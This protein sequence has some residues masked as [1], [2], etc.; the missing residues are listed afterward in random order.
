MVRVAVHPDEGRLLCQLDLSTVLTWPGT[1]SI[2]KVGMTSEVLV[3]VN[4]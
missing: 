3:D 4:E 2:C 1:Q